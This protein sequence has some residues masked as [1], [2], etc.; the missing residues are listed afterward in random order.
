M[1]AATSLLYGKAEAIV[2]DSAFRDFKSLCKQVSKQYSPKY[3]PSCLVECLFLCIFPKLKK[4]VKTKAH[5]NIE[6]LNVG[7]AV[8]KISPDTL[9][10]LLSGN[11][12]ELINKCNSEKLIQSFP[13]QRKHFLLFEGTHNS[14]R[15]PEIIRRVFRLL[16]DH[17]VQGPPSFK[18]ALETR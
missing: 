12:D 7:A 4:D 11:S 2:A 5:Y 13:G 6:L 10:I 16:E 9:L 14:E 8:K 3:I 17:F 18:A 1:G 15:P